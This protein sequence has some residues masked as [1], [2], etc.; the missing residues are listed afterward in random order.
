VLPRHDYVTQR[1]DDLIVGDLIVTVMLLKSGGRSFI[2]ALSS[3]KS[4]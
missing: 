4:V 2:A 3:G 1:V